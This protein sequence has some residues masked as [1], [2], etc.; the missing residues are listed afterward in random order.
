M[1]K[2]IFIIFLILNSVNLF[3]Q[4]S[5]MIELRKLFD[6]ATT[7][8]SYLE[9]AEKYMNDNKDQAAFAGYRSMLLFLNAQYRFNP[10]SKLSDFNKGKEKMEAAVALY[11]ND[12]ETRFLRLA[13][14]EK[15]PSFL[16]YNGNKKADK[17]FLKTHYSSIK[18]SDL[19]SRIKLFFTENKLLTETEL[20]KL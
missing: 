4:D 8:S 11:P 1:K 18:D 2:F 19:K 12:I 15:I 14:Q 9:K 6:K 13:I 7:T 17:E 10:Y 3:A 5:V 16:G 20:E